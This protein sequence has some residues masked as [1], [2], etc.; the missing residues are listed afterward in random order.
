MSTSFFAIK[1]QKT[2]FYDTLKTSLFLLL[3]F[4][5]M[6][7]TLT[8]FISPIHNNK[9]DFALY[10][11]CA[12]YDTLQLTFAAQIIAFIIGAISTNN[13]E[14]LHQGCVALFLLSLLTMIIG[15]TLLDF[16][17]TKTM[18]QLYNTMRKSYVERFLWLNNNKTEVLGVG[19]LNSI[20][21]TGIEVWGAI[22]MRDAMYLAIYVI[23]FC[24]MIGVITFSLGIGYA[25]LL[26]AFCFSLGV[27]TYF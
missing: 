7:Q 27:I 2:A 1:L 4:P 5:Y 21:F 22:L 12:L 10:V 19:K 16:Q 24:Y 14:H 18:N 20:I 11:F 25:F 17:F 15:G 9:K 23:S 8:R 13:I 3:A 6:F 26:G